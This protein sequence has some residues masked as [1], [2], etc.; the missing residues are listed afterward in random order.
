MPELERTFFMIKPDG[1]QRG[2]I[3]NIMSTENTY[4]FSTIQEAPIVLYTSPTDGEVVGTEISQI[5]FTLNDPQGDLMDYTV[6]TSP[7][8]GGK[9][10]SNVSDGTYHVPVSGIVKDTWYYWYVNAT[11]G[12][13]WSYNKFSFNTGNYN[14]LAYWNFNEGTGY[15]LHDSS[16][17]G[18]D[19]SIMQSKWVSGYI[20]KAIK[21]SGDADIVERISKSLDNMG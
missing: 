3:G 21:F 5:S 8:I 10:E 1:V 19:G 7:D 2:L 13:H 15:T 17:N 14:F 6:E 4:R 18:Y 16:G 20:G 11:D 12:T 9:S